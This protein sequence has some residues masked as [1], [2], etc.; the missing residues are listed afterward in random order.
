[1]YNVVG[2]LSGLDSRYREPPSHNR[3]R[4]TTSPDGSIGRVRRRSLSRLQ[5]VADHLAGRLTT[6]VLDMVVD[7]PFELRRERDDPSSRPDRL[8]VGSLTTDVPERC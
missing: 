3:R 1:V 7:Q 2:G 6:A 5:G 4:G 8:A